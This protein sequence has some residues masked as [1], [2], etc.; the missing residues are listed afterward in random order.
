MSLKDLIN[1]SGIRGPKK[2]TETA[3]TTLNKAGLPNPHQSWED[4]KAQAKQSQA[5]AE[6][7]SSSNATA[8]AKLKA[9]TETV[10]PTAEASAIAAS[11]GS[12]EYAPWRKKL[13]LA[14]T[15]GI[16]T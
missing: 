16:N 8:A 13:S 14:N 15:L 1:L 11:V 2:V 9:A 10:D 4:N 12:P 7:L 5:N 3:S 6:A